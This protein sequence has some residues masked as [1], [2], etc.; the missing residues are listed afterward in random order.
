MATQLGGGVG[1][2][3]VVALHRIDVAAMN[4][5]ATL[6]C[7]QMR[8]GAAAQPA[9]PHQHVPG[10]RNP[11]TSSGDAQP[12]SPRGGTTPRTSPQRHRH[13]ALV[14]SG[15]HT[16]AQGDASKRQAAAQSTSAAGN[17]GVE[18]KKFLAPGTSGQ[19]APA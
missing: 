9:N 8:A 1:S 4:N 11:A 19:S 6:R 14:C 12:M 2:A 16:S 13:Q 15:D 3:L 10:N 5:E 17:D 7:V 18:P